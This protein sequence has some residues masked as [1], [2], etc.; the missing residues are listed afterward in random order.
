MYR[1]LI[2]LVLGAQT[3]QISVVGM[4]KHMRG[5]NG[6]NQRSGCPAGR[7]ASRTLDPDSDVDSQV[8]DES[9]QPV[10][11]PHGAYACRR[12]G[13]RLKHTAHALQQHQA[14]GGLQLA[15]GRP[16]W[17]PPAPEERACDREEVEVGEVVVWNLEGGSV[18]QELASEGRLTGCCRRLTGR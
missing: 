14:P 2:F 7:S 8:E 16:H 15:A 13:V 10:S 1:K 12:V 4:L 11:K 9:K 6:R 17:Q 3:V 18:V 5:E